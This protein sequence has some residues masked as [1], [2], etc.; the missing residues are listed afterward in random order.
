[1]SVHPCIMMIVSILHILAANLF[2]QDFNT[3]NCLYASVQ[4]YYLYL[5]PAQQLQFG[6]RIN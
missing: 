3:A 2:G 4:R 6:L 1:M 5:Y